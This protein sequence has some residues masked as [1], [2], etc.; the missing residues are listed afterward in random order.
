MSAPALAVGARRL[1][2]PG[3]RSDRLFFAQVHEDPCLEIEALAPAAGDR[4]VVVSSGGCTALSLLAAH[5][6]QVIAVDL[7]TTQNHL[8]ELKRVAVLRLGG[9]LAV[10]FLGGACGAPAF[11][12]ATYDGLRRDLSSAARAHWDAHRGDLARGVLHTGASER[13]LTLIARAIKVCI[14]PE[15]RIRRLLTCRT[16]AEQRAFYDREW[17]SWRWRALFAVLLNR[18]AFNRSHDPSFF[19]HVENPSFSR[20][21]FQMAAH[22][23]TEVPVA[24]NYFLH[25]ALTGAYPAIAGGALPPY[26]TAHG[27][28]TVAAAADRLTL[29]DGG[30]TEYLRTQPDDSVTGF[31]MSN[32]CEWLPPEEVE[33]LFAEV[34]RT[35][36]PGAPVC[37]RNFVGWTDVPARWRD[38]IVEDRERGEEMSRRDRSL[39]QRRFAI[40]R[41][42]K[43]AA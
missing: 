19:R 23:L 15:R 11:R 2:L 7:N 38:V 21:F 3:A 18:W 12:L 27:A 20:H 32:I 25:I 1:T 22:A 33:R 37:F 43:E 14:H 10:G 36:V 42:E 4:I 28:A 13:F 6:G 17:N 9:P 34:A 16:L 24:D 35:A 26:L 41:V 29:V 30:Y 40:C 8:I 5:A 31:V 39:V